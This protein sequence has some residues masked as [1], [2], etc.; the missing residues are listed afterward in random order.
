MNKW[1][2]SM[3]VLVAGVSLGGMPLPFS[4]NFDLYANDTPMANLASNGW[5]ASDSRVKVETNIVHFGKAVELPEITTLSNSIT[6][7]EKKIW[8]DY[9]VQPVLGNLPPAP[10]T[11]TSSFFAYA[12]T[13]GYLV[14]AVDGGGW[15]VC[16]NQ[17]DNT[18]AIPL[19]TNAFARISVCQDY[20]FS[21]PKF[22]VF[23]AGNLVAQGLSA[24]ANVGSFSSFAMNNLDRS[25]YLDDLL[26]STALPSGLTSDLDGNGI[27]DALEIHIYGLTGV[28][29]K[30]TMLMVQ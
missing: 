5:Y 25:A 4:D 30:G 27:P 12:N 22:A 10:P 6:S 28:M 16:S 14:V 29:K 8:L 21:P 9:Y 23:V 2:I 18:P 1:I 24:P 17:L 20:N 7:T 13:N 15:L 19:Q 11:N 3:V 26:V